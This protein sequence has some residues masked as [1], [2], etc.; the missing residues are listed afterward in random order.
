[1]K[2]CK[3]FTWMLF[4]CAQLRFTSLAAEVEFNYS[5]QPFH[6]P[7]AIEN[8]LAADVNNDDLND[9]VAV[10]ENVMRIY[11]QT[12]SGFDFDGGYIE[13]EIPGSAV[14]WDLSTN[15]GGAGT[16]IIALIDGAEVLAWHIDGRTI[17]TPRTIKSGL[18]GYLGRGINRLH[19]SRDV[20]NDG[21][22]DLII[23]GAGEL[24]LYLQGSNGDYLTPLPVK[25]DVQMRTSLDP[26]QLER[27]TGQAITIPVLELR[28]L[29]GDAAADIVSRTEEKLDV[30]L[31]SPAGNLYFPATPSYSIN[32]AE[33]EAGL[34]DF[35][36]D[37]LDFSNLTG[38][39]ALT[40]EEILDDVNGDGID[41]LLLREG[42]KVSLFGGTKTGMNLSEPLQVLRSSGNVLSTFLYDENEDNLKDL[43]LWRVESISVGD[44][45]VWLALSGSVSIEAFIYPNEGE[46][47]ARRPSRQ[48]TVELKF[49]SAIRLATSFLEIRN[50]VERSRGIASTPANVAH[51][52]A[53]TSQQELLVML[54]RQLQI[55]LNSIAPEPETRP[56]LGSLGYSRQRNN[57]EIDI[58]RIIDNLAVNRDPLLEQVEGRTA[59]VVIDLAVEVKTGDI[60]PVRLNRDTVDDLLLF[61]DFDDKQ[62]TGVLLLSSESSAE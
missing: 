50:E 25:S 53:D 40:H 8:L 49:P 61:T 23:P 12:E 33:I 59:D 60:I 41:D 26:E 7:V 3:A 51:L 21:R 62:I 6:L 11:F 35:D 31:A 2:F 54:D 13:F 38:V 57:Y 45:F 24:M 47:F 27:R 56:F 36:V 14:G 29:N 10:V 18:S 43:W 52:D 48:I 1:M 46:R 15:Y 17:Q 4:A 34:G 20:N 58:R 22:D 30:F 19:F 37:N 28:D 44:I 42:G 39:L 16:A 55:F 32:I 9:L 5:S